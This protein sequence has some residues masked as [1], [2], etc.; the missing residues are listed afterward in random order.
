MRTGVCDQKGEKQ[1]IILDLLPVYTDY[2]FVREQNHADRSMTMKACGSEHVVASML[3]EACIWEHE[4]GS[5]VMG[6]FFSD[7]LFSRIMIF[8]DMQFFLLA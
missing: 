6:A 5:M 4:D 2:I 1:V 8:N 7:N 3:M